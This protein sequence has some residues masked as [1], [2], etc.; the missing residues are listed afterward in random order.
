MSDHAPSEPVVA[1]QILRELHRQ[2]GDSRI[3]FKEPPRRILGGFEAFTYSFELAE[4]PP[5]LGGPLILRLFPDASDAARGLREAAFQNSL[6][7]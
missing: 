1:A 7:P 2:L 6:T 4:N 5:N 3:E